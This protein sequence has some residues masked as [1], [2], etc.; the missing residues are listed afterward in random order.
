MNVAQGTYTHA[1]AVNSTS[2]TQQF[3]YYSPSSKIVVGDVSEGRVC[4]FV[5]LDDTHVQLKLYSGVTIPLCTKACKFEESVTD[6]ESITMMD[7][8]DI[9][10]P[11]PEG[12]EQVI[13]TGNAVGAGCS[14]ETIDLSHIFAPG[15]QIQLI[16]NC[17]DADYVATLPGDFPGGFYLI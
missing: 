13:T 12:V 10:E 11:T 3:E 6:N 2:G 16:Q 8:V 14:G 1:F 17:S 4:T 15:A 5:L 7:S 9:P